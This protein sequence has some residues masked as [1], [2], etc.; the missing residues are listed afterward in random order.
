MEA[1]MR[2]TLSTALAALLLTATTASAHHPFAQDF[3]KDKPVTLNG[4]VMR[5]Q[6]TNPHVY[7]FVKVKDDQGK[8]AT[9]KV[10][11]GSPAAL[12]MNGW[13]RPT[14]KTGQM[15]TL[16]GW[17]AKNGTNFAN[18]EDVTTSD[19]KK[20][21]AASSYDAPNQGD[22]A[23]TRA[24]SGSSVGTSGKSQP[25]PASPAPEPPKKY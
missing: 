2:S 22:L 3:D 19:G 10:E 11:M 6:W 13:T 17:H 7:T 20:L 18:A 23:S 14:L 5:V 1:C 25:A 16:Q 9:W 21:S 24:K 15:V 8:D 12:M 4:T